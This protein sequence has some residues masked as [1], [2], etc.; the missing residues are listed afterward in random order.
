MVVPVPTRFW[1]GH[2]VVTD[3]DA[4]QTHSSRATRHPSRGIKRSRSSLPDVVWKVVGPDR[5]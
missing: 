3:R 2:F 5:R 1:I 4:E